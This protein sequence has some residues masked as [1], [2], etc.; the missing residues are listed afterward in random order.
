MKQD[1]PKFRLYLISAI[2]GLLWTLFMVSSKDPISATLVQQTP[3]I[4]S[5]IQDSTY[6]L[7][8]LIRNM[9]FGASQWLISASK[10]PRHIL[11][12]G[13]EFQEI[14]QPFV[15]PDDGLLLDLG[16]LMHFGINEIEIDNI[17][18]SSFHFQPLISATD[19]IFTGLLTFIGLVPLLWALCGFFH[20]R[21][22]QFLILLIS[23]IPL[24]IYWVVTPYNIRGY[25]VL[26][27]GGHLHFITYVGTLMKLPPAYAG[28]EY[29]QPP[30]YYLTAALVWRLA[31]FVQISPSSTA[32]A[33]SMILW[34]VFVTVGGAIFRLTLRGKSLRINMA[35][36]TLAFWPS[37]SMHAVR[38]GNDSMLYALTAFALFFF[39]RYWLGHH[40]AD[41]WGLSISVALALLT[42]SNALVMAGLFGLF[43]L[44]FA[45]QR[46]RWVDFWIYV[47]SSVLG[48]LL[49]LM[50][51]I[52][53]YWKG[54][55][56]DWLISNVE[57]LQDIPI[58]NQVTNFLPIQIKT[59]LTQ[60]WIWSEG[61]LSCGREY[62]WNYLLRTSLSG[63]FK[64]FDSVSCFVGYVQGG[65]L[66]LLLIGLIGLAIRSFAQWKSIAVRNAH[67]LSL[68]AL[69]VLSM[70]VLRYR[71][72]V[73]CSA[74]F[75]YIIPIIIPL[76]IAVAHAGRFT[77]LVMLL[78]G[79]LSLVF[80]LNFLTM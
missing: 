70:L 52:Y 19:K 64:Y 3:Q 5:E 49:G 44:F 50:D 76:G 56:G 32:Q 13:K 7:K 48:N 24:A 79:G 25:D 14:P 72:K 18:D 20:L 65:L 37:A 60:P 42:K 40:R 10:Q 2:A 74:D 75:R 51:N 46:K 55:V 47:G 69:W 45:I 31:D 36:L 38:L 43:L 21:R 30:F 57:S 41:V 9:G 34:L 80:Y 61:D 4:D 12:N 66:L 28:W 68:A 11:V 29:Y 33:Y 27:P 17:R 22:S 62:F 73:S 26:R 63:Q 67:W 77:H 54:F 39:H 71:M 78:M 16:S 35:T 8:F 1:H 53:Y 59:F 23:L 58:S 15:S 6:S